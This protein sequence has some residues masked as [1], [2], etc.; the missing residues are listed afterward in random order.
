VIHGKSHR[1]TYNMDVVHFLANLVVDVSK[2][3]S[4]RLIDC[5]FM[6]TLA[7]FQ[8]DRG[9]LSCRQ[10]IIHLYLLYWYSVFCLI[11]MFYNT[12]SEMRPFLKIH[13]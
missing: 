8:L 12:M 10:M 5:Y 9:A 13:F 4:C 7:E 6:P 1:K 3:I 2:R 11:L